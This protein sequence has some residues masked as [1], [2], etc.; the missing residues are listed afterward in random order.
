[1]AEHQ[2]PTTAF[3]GN[4]RQVRI[5]TSDFSDQWYYGLLNTF[6]LPLA[7]KYP[8]TP[9]WFTR[10]TG[11]DEGDTFF[12]AL[13][14]SFKSGGDH[15]SIR[16]RLCPSSDEEQ[17][18]ASLSNQAYWWS[19]FRDFDAMEA[20]SSGR[21]GDARN[22]GY[23]IR[24]ASVTASLL[25][26]NCRYVLT[27][28]EDGGGC[29]FESNSDINSRFTG[30]SFQTMVHLMSQ[31]MDSSNGQPLPLWWCRDMPVLACQA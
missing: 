27:L 7:K 13:P 28:L 8:N 19:D 22:V 6:V 18:V 26:A 10:Y 5:F 15:R 4:W 3:N 11:Q 21:F 9:L 25:C 24:R 2:N 12:A 31:I 29:S 23:R 16:L 30:N 14:P 1:M 20:F 17:Y